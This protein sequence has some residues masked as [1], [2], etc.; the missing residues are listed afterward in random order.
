MPD[1]HLC[2]LASAIRCFGGHWMVLGA[3]GG[4]GMQGCGILFP[5][6]AGAAGGTVPPNP[7]VSNYKAARS[8]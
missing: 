3:G 5:C 2:P 4:W 1:A 8:H 7:I 6:M